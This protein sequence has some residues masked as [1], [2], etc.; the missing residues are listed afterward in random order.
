MLLPLTIA[1]VIICW[2]I[3]FCLI[4]LTKIIMFIVRHISIRFDGICRSNWMT[5]CVCLVS[6]VN[7]N[8]SIFSSILFKWVCQTFS[9]EKPLTTMFNSFSV[10]FCNF[11]SCKL[12][13][14]SM[15]VRT[16]HE[17]REQFVSILERP[18]KWD[19]SRT[20]SEVNSEQWTTDWIRHLTEW[21]TETKKMSG[22]QFGCSVENHVKSSYIIY[23]IGFYF[24]CSRPLYSL[25]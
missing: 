15:E 8:R 14:R 18:L 17:Q 11:S 24:Y 20:K 4:V 19:F 2:A 16:V 9:N 10:I 12:C 25:Y 1:N 5:E 7:A 23:F 13:Y 3:S 6:Y 22:E 21:T